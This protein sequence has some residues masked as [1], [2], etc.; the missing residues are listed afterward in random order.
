MQSNTA[1]RARTPAHFLIIRR[2]PVA[3]AQAHGA[4]TRRAG[5]PTL[6]MPLP[7]GFVVATRRHVAPAAA[8]DGAAAVVRTESC[9]APPGCSAPLRPLVLPR[10]CWRVSS[11]DVA[12][13]AGG[14][15]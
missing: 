7:R 12:V 4:P 9:N 2:V 8:L 11:S 15:G 6:A 3:P 10:W 5:C 13:R 1:P 14:A